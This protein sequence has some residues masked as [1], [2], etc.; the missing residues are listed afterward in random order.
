MIMHRF[1][2]VETSSIGYWLPNGYSWP[3]NKG[4]IDSW[5]ITKSRISAT[6][7]RIEDG[8]IKVNINFSK[9]LV[10]VSPN[11]LSSWSD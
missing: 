10:I 3:W 4:E 8:L 5:D 9:E 7:Y 2:D 1:K 6:H 11:E